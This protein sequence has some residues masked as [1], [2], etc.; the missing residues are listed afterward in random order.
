MLKSQL[1]WYCLWGS[2]HFP[3]MKLSQETVASWVTQTNSK[4]SLRITPKLQLVTTLTEQS[5]SKLLPA[6]WPAACCWGSAYQKSLT[7][8]GTELCCG[9]L[10][11]LHTIARSRL[12][13]KCIC[14]QCPW[15]EGWCC[16]RGV[17]R[18]WFVAGRVALLDLQR[19]LACPAQH[20]TAGLRGSAKMHY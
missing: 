9:S 18:W 16:K 19:A 2:F 6:T 14:W 17:T 5:T 11:S 7:G 4:V 10:L 15:S 20:G 1:L 12:G 8:A 3:P 13:I